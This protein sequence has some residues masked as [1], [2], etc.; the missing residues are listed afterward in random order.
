VNVLI[1]LGGGNEALDIDI[2]NL[3]HHLHIIRVLVGQTLI[4]VVL[5]QF[6][7]PN[8]MDGN[9][10]IPLSEFI[11]VT[12]P[13]SVSRVLLSHNDLDI[14]AKAARHGLGSGLYVLFY[15]GVWGMSW[16]VTHATARL[17]EGVLGRLSCVEEC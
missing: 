9:V 12:L 2:N 14:V 16:T 10:V 1:S 13:M 17:R 11:D 15:G 6:R 8:S 7:F 3:A 5:S 4:V